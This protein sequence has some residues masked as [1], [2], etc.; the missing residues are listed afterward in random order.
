MLGR[1]AFTGAILLTMGA[2]SALA[3]PFFPWAL[4]HH[5]ASLAKSSQ[6]A[7][8][9]MVDGTD[10]TA[11]TKQVLEQKG[12]QFSLTYQEGQNNLAF[13]GQ[14]GTDQ[15]SLTTQTGSNNHGFTYQSGD[16]QVSSTSKSGTGGWSA[17]SSVG[18]HT[19]TSVSLSS[20]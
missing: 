20:D 4:V 13:T 6:C 5:C 14:N 10:D 8:Q 12:V 1:V 15:A 17:T 16:H 19:A 7:V 3:A 9:V 11:V 18:S 2:S